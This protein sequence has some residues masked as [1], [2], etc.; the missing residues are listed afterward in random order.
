MARCRSSWDSGIVGTG[1]LSRRAWR[2]FL[3]AAS[4]RKKN[5]PGMP[6][7]LGERL[8]VNRLEGVEAGSRH[9]FVLQTPQDAADQ[10]E[11]LEGG[12][13]AFQSVLEKVEGRE[14]FA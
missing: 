7:A 11:H 10:A 4:R 12:L 2:R 8:R 14:R 1:S 6:R 3:Q 5:R 13:I 9:P